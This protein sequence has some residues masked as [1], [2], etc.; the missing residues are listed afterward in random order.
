MDEKCKI[1]NVTCVGSQL[2]IILKFSF[3]FLFCPPCEICVAGD[4]S[5]TNPG[6]DHWPAVHYKEQE[7]NE[8]QNKVSVRN[9][10]I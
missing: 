5:S 6:I 4:W 10:Q 8:L 1:S 3:F 9:A 7:R 2:V